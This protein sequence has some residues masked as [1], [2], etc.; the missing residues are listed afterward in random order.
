[1]SKQSILMKM[2]DMVGNGSFPVSDSDNLLA[3]FVDGSNKAIVEDTEVG[4]SDEY[5]QPNTRWQ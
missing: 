4:G 3:N 2:L 5:I 1:M